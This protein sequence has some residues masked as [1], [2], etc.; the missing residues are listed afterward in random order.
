[1]SDI[2]NSDAGRIFVV[3]QIGRRVMEMC[4]GKNTVTDIVASIL[5][6]C[7]NATLERVNNDITRFLT[8][9][10]RRGLIEWTGF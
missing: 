7:K 9:A 10:A 3:N 4:D 6:Q 8:E 1:M 5:G 2:V